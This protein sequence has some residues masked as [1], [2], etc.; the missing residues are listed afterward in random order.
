MHGGFIWVESKPGEGSAFSFRIPIKTEKP[1]TSKVDSRQVKK[2]GTRAI[3]ERVVA[4]NSDAPQILVVEDDLKTS[5]LL[6]L[7]LTQSGYRVIYAYDG[8]EAVPEDLALLRS[9]FEPMR[10][11]QPAWWQATFFCFYEFGPHPKWP[12][13]NLG[14]WNTVVN[15]MSFRSDGGFD[16]AGA[17]RHMIAQPVQALAQE[18]L[19]SVDRAIP[20]R[21]IK[22]FIFITNIVRICCFSMLLRSFFCS[23]LLGR[24][25]EGSLKT[26]TL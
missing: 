12:N 3:E 24:R 5:K 11:P 18:E 14:L 21:H 15:L 2:T 6:G 19:R 22:I 16:L 9:H 8:V 20:I 13:P 7:Y 26:L 17:E 25:E 4:S 10:K 23:Y 1:A